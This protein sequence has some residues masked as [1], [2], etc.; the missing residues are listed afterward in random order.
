M[1]GH[2][3]RRIVHAAVTPIVRVGGPAVASGFKHFLQFIGFGLL[4]LVTILVSWLFLGAESRGL[5]SSP[6]WSSSRSLR[7]ALAC[8]LPWSKSG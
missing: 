5:S 4:G 8:S 2:L 6:L 7:W 1:P 3:A